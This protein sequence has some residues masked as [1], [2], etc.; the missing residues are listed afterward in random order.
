MTPAQELNAKPGAVRLS[1]AE[2]LSYGFGDLG[3]SLPYNMVSGVLLFYYVNVIRLPAAAVGTIFLIARLMDA[4]IDMGVGI[5]VDRTRS[6]WGRTRPYFLAI[7]LPYAAVYVA[8]FSMPDWSQQAQL[9]YAFV[10]FKALGILMSLGAIPY[11]ALLPMMTND[12]GER[13]KLSGMRSLGTSLSVVL[14][15]A[16]VAPLLAAFGGETHPD[17]Y[18]K[19]AMIFAVI[20]ITAILALF[21]NC[22]ERID[23][24]SNENAPLLPVLGQMLRNRAWLVAFFFCLTYFVRFGGMMAV[25]FNLAIDVLRAPWMIGWMLPGVAG[26]LLLSAFVGPPIFARTGIRNGCVA[27]VLI[28]AALFLILPLFEGQPVPFLTIYFAACLSTSITITAAFTMIAQTVDYHEEHYGSRN[29]G[30][31]SAGVSLATKVGMALGTSGIAFML[32]ASDYSP[33]AVT[34]TARSAIRWTYYGGTAAMLVIQ[35]V[36]VWFWPMD[37]RGAVLPNRKA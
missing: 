20:S 33:D 35:A 13:L 4:V 2:R 12:T 22:R 37:S 9:V 6:R 32:A 1:L 36:V 19:V 30:L 15:T 21:A 10:T 24:R 14:G 28:A 26:T 3:F 23:Q 29:E 27:S 17:G 8:L 5:A 7:A 18:R 25:T 11:T 16:V 31:L 34:E